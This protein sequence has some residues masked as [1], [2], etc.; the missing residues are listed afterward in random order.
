MSDQKPPP[1]R[2]S[3]DRLI[4]AGLL[5]LSLATLFHLADKESL[6]FLGKTAALC[7]AVACPLLATSTLILS[8]ASQYPRVEHYPAF[9]LLI[10][11]IGTLLTFI[12]ADLVLW[13]S[14]RWVGTAFSLTSFIGFVLWGLFRVG[15]KR[16]SKD[17]SANI[18]STPRV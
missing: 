18:E 9:R 16:R 12:G 10:L 14:N 3:D 4:C 7:F 6:D 8:T 5:G 11:V 17:P 1:D 15:I 2:H 13:R